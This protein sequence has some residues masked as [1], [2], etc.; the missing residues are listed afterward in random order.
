MSESSD[1]R[2]RLVVFNDGCPV[3]GGLALTQ[4]ALRVSRELQGNR[5]VWRLVSFRVHHACASGALSTPALELVGALRQ[6]VDE[7]EQRHA[8][9]IGPAPEQAVLAFLLS[10]LLDTRASH[11]ELS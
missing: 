1:S 9:E 7:L 11:L 2:A 8:E 3:C 10:S 4:A 5:G 6:H